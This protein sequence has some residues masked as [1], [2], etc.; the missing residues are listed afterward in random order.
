MPERIF[1]TV[2]NQLKITLP[3]SIFNPGELI[4]IVKISKVEYEGYML[5][6]QKEQ[7]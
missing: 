3:K 4:M 5:N 1:T 2:P 7:S 6:L